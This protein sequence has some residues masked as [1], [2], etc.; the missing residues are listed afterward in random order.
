MIWIHQFITQ[1][2]VPQEVLSE[3]KI[4]VCEYNSNSGSLTIGGQDLKFIPKRVRGLVLGLFF[5]NKPSRKKR[6]HW[7]EII[8]EIEGG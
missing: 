4:L 1:Q 5:K 7:E 6:L 2:L 3:S 8:D